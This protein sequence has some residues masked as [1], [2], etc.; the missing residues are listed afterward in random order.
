MEQH[1]PAPHGPLHSCAPSLFLCQLPE[2]PLPLQLFMAPLLSSSSA[3]E[4]G[5]ENRAR[6]FK[7]AHWEAIFK[8]ALKTS[9]NI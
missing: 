1:A 9:K 7:S 4:W 3:G 5:F 8:G 6:G 2:L